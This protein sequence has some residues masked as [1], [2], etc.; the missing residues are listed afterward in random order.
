MLGVHFL[1]HMT[2]VT[3]ESQI[4]LNQENKI[5]LTQHTKL[6]CWDRFIYFLRFLNLMSGQR[7]TE[8]LIIWWEEKPDM[9]AQTHTKHAADLFGSSDTEN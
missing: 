9:F 8:I 3:K 2:A 6:P 4:E 7:E 1:V 5:K